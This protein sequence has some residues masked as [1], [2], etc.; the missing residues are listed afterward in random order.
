MLYEKPLSTGLVILSMGLVAPEVI[1]L[2]EH[3]QYVPG[4]SMLIGAVVGAVALYFGSG[5]ALSYTSRPMRASMVGAWALMSGTL[6]LLMLL[7]T[8]RTSGSQQLLFAA[9]S[10]LPL[11]GVGLSHVHNRQR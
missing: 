11:L 8:L 4:T 5:V 6:A 3:P 1:N 10:V 2:F 9:S 7:A